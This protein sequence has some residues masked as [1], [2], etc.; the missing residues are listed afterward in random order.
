MSA[1]NKINL[2]NKSN[3]SI[4]FGGTLRNNT[5]RRNIILLA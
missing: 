3:C 5:D 1:M 4:T 2:K